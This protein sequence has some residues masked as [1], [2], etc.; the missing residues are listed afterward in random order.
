MSQTLHAHMNN[1]KIKIKKKNKK[2]SKTRENI[3]KLHIQGFAL[4]TLKTES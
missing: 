1:K 4:S 2:T 3:L